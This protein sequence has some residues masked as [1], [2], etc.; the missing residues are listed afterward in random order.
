MTVNHIGAPISETESKTLCGQVRP[1]DEDLFDEPF[2]RDCTIACI[3]LME[4]A[5]E[6]NFE[7]ENFLEFVVENFPSSPTNIFPAAFVEG[8]D[9]SA[10]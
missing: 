8:L 10:K 1:R 3:E 5:L 9:L 6:R 7:L 4:K 2:C